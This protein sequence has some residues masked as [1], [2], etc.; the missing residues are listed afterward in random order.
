[1]A[2]ICYVFVHP[3]TN[4]VVSTFSFPGKISTGIDRSPYKS[5]QPNKRAKELIDQG[6]V[7]IGWY[8]GFNINTIQKENG[9]R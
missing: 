1:M 7:Y 8:H 4:D 3:E 2:S 9:R 6:Y 5:N